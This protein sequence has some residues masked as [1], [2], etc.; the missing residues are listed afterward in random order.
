GDSIAALQK[1]HG[2]PRSARTAGSRTATVVGAETAARG[3]RTAT[4]RRTTAALGAVGAHGIFRLESRHRPALDG[5]PDV[6][7]DLFQ[8]AHVLRGRER[9]RGA[10]GAGA[11]GA[12]DAV[13]VVL[14]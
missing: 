7:L 5:A 3:R 2:R 12:A 8:L 9:N 11:A 13:H 10:G 1:L 6:T 14:G 4:R